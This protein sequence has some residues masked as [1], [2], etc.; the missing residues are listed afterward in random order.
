LLR[1]PDDE[2]VAFYFTTERR[3]GIRS[4][5][6]GEVKRNVAHI[7]ASLRHLGI[8]VGD[9]VSLFNSVQ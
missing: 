9:R 8:Q 2:K 6:F 4:R 3:D 7:A 1:Y 5:T